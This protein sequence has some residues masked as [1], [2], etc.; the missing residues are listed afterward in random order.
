MTYDE[1][2]NGLPELNGHVSAICVLVDQHGTVMQQLYLGFDPTDA[3]VVE[4]L[5]VKDVYD[6]SVISLMEAVR[7]TCGVWQHN[8][9]QAC[10]RNA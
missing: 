1:W 9:A 8:I 5:K 2:K 4:R 7:Q 3:K 10:M 6:S